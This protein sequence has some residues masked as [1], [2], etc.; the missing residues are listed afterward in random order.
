MGR[1]GVVEGEVFYWLRTN[2]IKSKAVVGFPE[3]DLMGDGKVKVRNNWSPPEMQGDGFQLICS[4]CKAKPVVN[5]YDLAYVVRYAVS[6]HDIPSSG[7]PILID[8]N[9]EIL[10]VKN[11]QSASDWKFNVFGRSVDV[12]GRVTPV[13]TGQRRKLAGTSC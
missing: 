8:P 7:S 1:A 2:A 12:S 11:D 4:D 6:G 5:A 3:L 13:K 10:T 9:G